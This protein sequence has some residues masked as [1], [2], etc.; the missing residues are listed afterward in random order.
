MGYYGFITDHLDSLLVTDNHYSNDI[1]APQDV[2]LVFDYTSMPD[3]INWLQTEGDQIIYIYGENDPWSAAALEHIGTSHALL[4]MQSGGNH[5]LR[6]SDI[7]QYDEVIDSLESWLD[8]NLSYSAAFAKQ[9]IDFESE[10][11]RHRPY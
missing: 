8:M 11:Q 4:I 6:L 3:V 1:F 7:D 2:D 10:E 9:A 5:N